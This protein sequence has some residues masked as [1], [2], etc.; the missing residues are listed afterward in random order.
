VDRITPITSDRFRQELR[1]RFGVSDA[2][3]VFCERFRQWVVEDHF[4]TGRPALEEVGVQCVADVTPFE[5][6]KL[7]ILNGGHAALAYPAALLGIELVDQAIADP[8]LRA[9][10]DKLER[11]EIIPTVPPV[12]ETDLGDY[13]ALIKRRFADRRVADPVLRVCF[14]GSSRQPKFILPS[15]I[16]RVNDGQSIEALALVSA[17]WARY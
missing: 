4:P 16:D 12:P 1:D 6:M 10:L 2:W 13:F 7:R 11:E 14:D 5:H 17:A 9:F 8:Q 3:P 15:A